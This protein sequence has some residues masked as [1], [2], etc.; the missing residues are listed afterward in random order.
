MNKKLVLLNP[1]A[2]AFHA[3][4]T[5]TL[6]TR[7]LHK[8]TVAATELRCDQRNFGMTAPIP[9]EDAYLIAL[10][11]RACPNHD[12]YFDGRRVQPKNFLGGVTTIYDLRTD[13]V[14]DVRD[15][16]H[17]IMFYLPRTA[18]DAMAHETGMRRVGDLRHQPGVSVDDPVVRGLLSALLPVI[19][20]PEEA[21]PLF[22]DH[23]AS[24][25][26]AHVAHRY[27]A[28]SVSSDSPGGGGLAHWQERR[29]KEMMSESLHKEITLAELANECGLSVRHFARTFRKSTGV[30][31]HQ[32]LLKHRVDHAQELMRHRGLSLSEIAL[33][34]GFADQ[35]HFSRV[36]TAILG[37]SPGAWRRAT[38]NHAQPQMKRIA[39]G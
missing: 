17:S 24:A 38:L 21:H 37:T 23:L 39:S 18:L 27:D 34:S 16:F 9:R 26:I 12:L 2:D 35:S 29:V 19:S 22:L 8:S 14:A 7:T 1:V 33:A 13:P 20:K 28:S 10:Q 15:P 25:L 3:P 4:D 36:F 30:T 6:H 11:I 5:P 32:W 31:P